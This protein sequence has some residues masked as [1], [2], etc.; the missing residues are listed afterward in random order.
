MYLHKINLQGDSTWNYRSAESTA[1]AADCQSWREPGCVC[2]GEGFLLLANASGRVFGALAS[3]GL[4]K[5]EVSTQYRYAFCVSFTEWACPEFDS[6][7]KAWAYNMLTFPW[8][9]RDIRCLC[10]KGNVTASR[11]KHLSEHTR[12]CRLQVCAGDALWHV[13]D[14]FTWNLT[15]ESR[16]LSCTVITATAHLHWMTV[17]E[18]AKLHLAGCNHAFSI[19]ILHIFWKEN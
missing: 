18:G 1:P 15:H 6:D 13:T 12:H 5:S 7:K 9:L 17:F 14:V 11:E 8:L 19:I 16:T 10:W 3:G 2:Y 4:L